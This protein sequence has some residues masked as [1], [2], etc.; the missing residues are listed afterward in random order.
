[1]NDRRFADIWNCP[2]A[3]ELLCPKQ[4]HDLQPTDS[5]NVRHCNVC[6][7][8]V[9]LS[10]T[11]AEFVQNCHL[12]RCVS[13]SAVG[14]PQELLTG[15]GNAAFLQQMREHHAK[16]Q[17]EAKIWWQMVLHLDPFLILPLIHKGFPTAGELLGELVI[18]LPQ[19]RDLWHRVDRLLTN[20]PKSTAIT[21]ATLASLQASIDQL[22]CLNSA[23][24]SPADDLP[25]VWE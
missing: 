25:D 23:S 16:I 20:S 4:W 19:E 7:E 22:D 10:P 15:K 2:E 11:P 1:M 17:S 5:D 8:R 13:I 14:M 6:N 9:Y 12:L 21:P 24:K 18:D 3:F